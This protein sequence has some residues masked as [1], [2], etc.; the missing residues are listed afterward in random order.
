MRPNRAPAG[1]LALLV[2][3]LTWPLITRAQVRGGGEARAL[4]QR[5][6]APCC[7]QQML[8]GHESDTARALRA[9]LRERFARGESPQAVER[10]LIERYGPN[11]I[12]VPADRD[13]RGALSWALGLL[14][15]CSAA[16]L[17][18]LAR[19]WRDASQREPEPARPPNPNSDPESEAELDT[20]LEAELRRSSSDSAL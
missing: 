6:H 1:L 12:A 18:M 5:L 8:E 11:I 13:P 20:R 7:R 19:R 3:S 17:F 10:S 9:E 2:M 4:E 14:L 15:T 16:G